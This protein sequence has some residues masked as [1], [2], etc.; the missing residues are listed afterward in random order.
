VGPLLWVL[1][2]GGSFAE[3]IRLLDAT[4]LCVVDRQR[5][6]LMIPSQRDDRSGSD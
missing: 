6:I 3:R 4:L 5:T 1:N 2:R